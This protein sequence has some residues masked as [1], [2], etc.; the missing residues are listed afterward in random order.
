MADSRRLKK[1]SDLLKR[2]LG[3]II[4]IRLQ[5]PNKG[6]ITLTRVKVSA[7]LKI[8]TVYYT[9]MGDENQREKTAEVLQR[10][11]SFLRNELKPHITSRWIPEL[12]FFYD[13]SMEQADRI[14]ELLKKI[15]NDS[16]T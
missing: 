16:G 7:D 12:R 6:F 9:V 1:Y 3:N 5:D 4:E 15:E 8:A 13:D 11:I 14:Y 10:S 2:T